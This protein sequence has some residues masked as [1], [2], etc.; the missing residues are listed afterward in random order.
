MWA[1]PETAEASAI[2]EEVGRSASRSMD[3]AALNVWRET[4]REKGAG[5]P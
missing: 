4:T 2:T 1:W 5:L 3:D